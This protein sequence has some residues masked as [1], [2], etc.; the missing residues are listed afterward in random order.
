[1]RV[2][3]IGGT[4][5]PVHVGHL[6]IAEEVRARLGL[7]RMVF[8]PAGTPPHKLSQEITD[9]EHRL[10]MVRLAIAGNPGLSVS[11]IDIDR[12]GRCYTVDTIRLLQ[13]AWG[14]K[15]EIYFLIGADSLAELPTWYRPERLFRLC[16]VVAVGRPGYRADLDE[17][18][19]WF[20]GAISVIRMFSVPEVDVSSTEIR[21]RVREGR[22]IDGLVPP[23][24]ERYIYEHHLYRGSPIILD[25]GEPI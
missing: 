4:F 8:V 5:D 9:P 1:M 15:A 10:E 24:V 18:N 25:T 23:S 11:R 14:A 6:I 22:S 12:P 13:D 17:L 3:V 21:Q 16:R 2:G 7:D 20:P 19:R